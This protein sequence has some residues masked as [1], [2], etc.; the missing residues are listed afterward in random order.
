[1]ELWEDMGREGNDSTRDRR[2]CDRQ[3]FDAIE[4][5]AGTKSGKPSACRLTSESYSMISRGTTAAISVS[6]RRVA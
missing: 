5:E 2:A 4:G 6:E 3:S 1:M